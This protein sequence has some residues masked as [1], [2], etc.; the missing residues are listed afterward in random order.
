[1]P[2]RPNLASFSPVQP[3]PPADDARVEHLAA[4]QPAFTPREAP[5]HQPAAGERKYP[6]VTVYLPADTIR[7]LKVIALEE[8]TRVNDLCAKAITDW[9]EANGHARGMKFKA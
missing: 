1:M 5:A 4:D 6:H 7:T 9:L 3:P 2:K 8:N